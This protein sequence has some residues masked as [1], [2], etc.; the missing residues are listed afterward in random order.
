MIWVVKNIHRNATAMWVDYTIS[1]FRKHNR[2][3]CVY[4]LIVNDKVKDDDS[5]TDIDIKMNSLATF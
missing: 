2:L 4:A 5:E 1:K 3:Q